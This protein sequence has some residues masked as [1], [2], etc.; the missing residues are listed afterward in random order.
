MGVIVAG[1]A[2]MRK[3]KF[4]DRT[5][6]PV[7]EAQVTTD[8]DQPWVPRDDADAGY[9]LYAKDRRVV[10]D[11]GTTI[12]YTVLGADGGEPPIL[13]ASGWSCSDSY[14][15]D[16]VP[17]FLERGHPVVLP[18][19][20][21]H[22]MSG[23]PRHPGRGARNLRDED[24]AIPR[25]AADLLAVL[26]DAGVDRVVLVGHSMGVQTS[27]EA[28]RQQRD[29]FLALVLIAGTYENPLRTL[30]GTSLVDRGFGLASTAMRWVPEIVSPV[31]VTIGNKK[32]GHMGARL[33]RAAGPKATPDAMHPY[34]LHLRTLEPPVMLKA[35][36]GMRANSAADLLPTITVPTLVVAAGKDVFTPV[37]CS[38][39]MHRAIPDSE[40]I[41]HPDGHHT[42]PIEEP[43]PIADAM[44]DFLGRHDV[45]RAAPATPARAKAK[46]RK[47]AKAKPGK[48]PT[49]AATA[50]ASGPG[51]HS[52]PKAATVT[53]PRGSQAR[54]R[55]V[56]AKTS[57]ASTDPAGASSPTPPVGPKKAVTKA[58]GAR[59]P[60][61]PAGP[62]QGATKAAGSSG[63]TPSV[64]PKRA[65]AK[66]AK[67]R[68]SAPGGGASGEADDAH[69]PVV[70]RDPEG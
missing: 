62:Q 55:N 68:R 51:D 57:S 12:A 17:R 20:R 48:A 59:G 66:A 63:P 15:V 10:V 31:W 3:R 5:N 8:L 49:K 42:L 41:V 64:G 70:D 36:A 34:L 47:V 37:R 33:A 54:K 69:P 60:T 65:V 2:A 24:V 53:K 18:D 23:L 45:L 35:A 27:L 32:V 61:P 28:Y 25:L 40:L 16:L 19:T 21:G 56:P 39:A 6:H 43:G 11:D 26:D 9:A 46:P 38:V 67:R 4:M 44:D 30:Y 13:L 29:R 50:S 7:E 14:W 22:G 58:A 1:H 52:Q